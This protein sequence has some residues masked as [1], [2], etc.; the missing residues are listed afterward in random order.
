MICSWDHRKSG[1]VDAVCV[2]PG[3]N[4]CSTSNTI[5]TVLG[6]YKHPD[7]CISKIQL[8]RS[9]RAHTEHS[10]GICIKV[11][12]LSGPSTPG[13]RDQMPE[14]APKDTEDTTGGFPGVQKKD[15]KLL[16]L[17]QRHCPLIRVQEISGVTEGI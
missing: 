7:D 11:E 6:M 4:S 13:Q 2:S 1:K 10:S 12:A 16:A 9:W 8:L 17:A 15:H 3:W 14:L 5:H